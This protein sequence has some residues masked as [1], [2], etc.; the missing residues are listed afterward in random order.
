MVLQ[1]ASTE[2]AL[3]PTL[4]QQ[5]NLLFQKCRMNAPAATSS[6]PAADS[7][8]FAPLF[9]RQA[10]EDVHVI[11]SHDDIITTP[12]SMHQVSRL[13]RTLHNAH[14]TSHIACCSSGHYNNL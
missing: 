3:K 13:P 7:Y 11:S 14:R 2:P 10:D 8:Q 4:Q 12:L 6:S 9:V 1:V 5:V